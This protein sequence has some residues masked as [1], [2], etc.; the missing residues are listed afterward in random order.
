MAWGSVLVMAAPIVVAMV[1]AWWIATREKATGMG[2]VAG[3]ISEAL[4]TFGLT[5]FA[6]CQV[7]AIVLLVRGWSRGHPLRGLF[8]VLSICLSAANLLLV[9]RIAWLLFVRP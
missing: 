5:S 1:G 3:G 7:T 4:T 9:V 2:A 6:A 8:A